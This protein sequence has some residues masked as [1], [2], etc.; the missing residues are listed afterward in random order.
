ML[1]AAAQQLSG[2]CLPGGLAGR[3]QT[4]LFVATSTSVPWSAAVAATCVSCLLPTHTQDQC[5]ICRPGVACSVSGVG[6][7]II[8][9]NLAR[10]CCQLMLDAGL[11]VESAC[12][13]AVRSS[14]LKVI[15]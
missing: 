2:T 15:E 7:A 13:Q 14:I 4:L 9:A 12:E 5:Q 10:A 1:L 6:E 11:S 3:P 8:R